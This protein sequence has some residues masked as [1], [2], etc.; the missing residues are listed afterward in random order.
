M[1]EE[2]RCYTFTDFMLREIQQGIQAG[3]ASMELVNKYLIEEGW[4]NGYAETVADWVQNHKTIVCLNGGMYGDVCD[5]RA[6]FEMHENPYPF[7]DFEEESH[8]G[9]NLTSVAVILP[10]RIFN[11]AAALR[12]AK[13]DDKVHVTW[14]Q[15]MC[16]LRVGWVTD[17][18][19]PLG[20]QHME[21]YNEWE[22]DLMNKLNGC[23]LAR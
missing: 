5:W 10:A 13:Y 9:G 11:G 3:H 7:A 15:L 18:G 4:Q 2:L 6:F 1:S 19:T 20:E 21:T 22:R 14:D 23:Q 8:Q 12:R 17:D 16:E